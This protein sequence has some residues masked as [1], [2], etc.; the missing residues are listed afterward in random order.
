MGSYAEKNSMTKTTNRAGLLVYRYNKGIREYLLVHPSGK[1]NAKS[2]YYIPKGHIEEGESEAETAIR[3][4]FEETGIV[5]KI[6]FDLGYITYKTKKKKKAKAFLAEYQSGKV[7]KNGIVDWSDW[8]NDIKI[9][10]NEKKARKLLRKEMIAFL[11]R[12][13]SYFATVGSCEICQK[14]DNGT[15]SFGFCNQCGA[16]ICRDCKAPGIG[17]TC[18]DCWYWSIGEEL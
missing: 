14:A 9:F 5:A 3:E 6:I 13:E 11:D 1:Y 16:P 4:T 7:L 18:N 15:E 10:V 17:W 12:A 2:P 8:E